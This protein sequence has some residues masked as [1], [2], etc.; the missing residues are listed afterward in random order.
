MWNDL[1]PNCHIVSFFQLLFSF[2]VSFTYLPHFLMLDESAS[3]LKHIFDLIQDYNIKLW[4]PSFC[5]DSICR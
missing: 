2:Q 3:K 5:G 1:Q 4:D